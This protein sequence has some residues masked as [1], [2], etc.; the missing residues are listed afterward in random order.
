MNTGMPLNFKILFLQLQL[1]TA[2][3]DYIRQAQVKNIDNLRLIK[4]LM[5][6]LMKT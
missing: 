2:N 4:L 3:T 1:Y 6:I 5:Q